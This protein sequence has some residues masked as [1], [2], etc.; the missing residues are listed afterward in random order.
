M[1]PRSATRKKPAKKSTP[2]P[3]PLDVESSPVRQSNTESEIKSREL[4]ASEN[5]CSSQEGASAA[6]DEEIKR[7]VGDLDA[8][9]TEVVASTS[10]EAKVKEE[11][12]EEEKNV[13]YVMGDN[14]NETVD[15]FVQDSGVGVAVADEGGERMEGVES[16]SGN[17]KNDSVGEV[18]EKCESA[19]E[20]K[21]AAV[22]QNDDRNVGDCGTQL[23]VVPEQNSCEE[24]TAAAQIDDAEALRDDGNVLAINEENDEEAGDDGGGQK[25]EV[26]GDGEGDNKA[27]N[28][29]DEVDNED[30]EHPS[31]FINNHMA[32][33]NKEKDLEV[34]IGSLD[35]GAVEDDLIKVFG[36][37]GEIRSAKVVRNR[38]TNKSRGF[39]FLQYAAVEQA[40]NALSHVKDGIQVRGKRVKISASQDN[41]TLYMGNICKLWTK[42]RV[43]ETLKSYGVENIEDIHLPDDPQKEGKIK[44]FALLEFSTHSDALAAF[45]QLRK[46]DAIFGRDRSAK[47]AFAQTPMH[48]NEEV[49]SQVK[50]VYVEGLTDAWN[51]EKVKE[52]CKPFGEVVKVTLSRSLGTK[53]KD[54]GFITFTSRESALA[55]VEGINNAHIGEGEVKVN[56]SIAKPHFKGRLQKQGTRGGFK[57]N[58]KSSVPS[59]TE[60][61]ERE[62]KAVSSKMKRHANSKLAKKKAKMVTE[63]KGKVP[64]EP[65]IGGGKPNKLQTVI[66]DERVQASSKL[67]RTNRKRKNPHSKADNRGKKRAEHGRYEKSSK[68]PQGN[69]RGRQSSNLRNPK[70]DP[71]MREGSNNGADFI[72]Y[73]NP[74]ALG[75]PASATSYQSHSHSTTSGSKRPYADMAPHAGYLEPVTRKQG[76]SSTGYLD[77]PVGMQYQAHVGYHGSAVRTQIQPHTRYREP[78]IGYH[79]SAVG[80]QIQP[81]TAYRE[82]AVGTHGQRQPHAGYLEPALGTHGQPLAVYLKPAVGEHGRPHAGYLEPAVGR[83]GQSH[84]GYSGPSVA[85]YSHTSYDLGSR[86]AG[87]QDLRGSG[88]PAYGA[89]S[90]L[91]R[92][93]IPNYTNYAGYKDGSSVGGHYQS[94]G[95]QAHVPRRAYY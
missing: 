70:R 40:K 2:K 61:I 46:P 26:V 83:P 59:I 32:Y 86:S 69:K 65:E 48:P 14:V 38:T 35:R 28:E 80:A 68:K 16:E 85:T 67:E 24:G 44:G 12:V 72:R 36:E 55:C 50:T 37:F 13:E 10:L 51:Q 87:G 42:E 25:K 41:D 43:L 56:A 20:E 29:D 11:V 19:A 23:A 33:R 39:A 27:D 62:N 78:H 22:E 1:P 66:E 57:V 89:G 63:E 5:N 88:Y 79:E 6:V 84:A 9:S 30:E 3:E 8:N 81:R 95:A 45:H 74:H 52:I 4:A 91:P 71:H 21:G 77:P 90:S 7:E 75:Y 73:S 64:S 76:R 47:V 94:S 18:T 93:Y 92:S 53:R 15:G 54:Y 31:E 60:E 82:P 34:F 17:E 49:L 58:E